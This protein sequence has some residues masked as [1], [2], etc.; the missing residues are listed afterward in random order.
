[1]QKKSGPAGARSVL[2]GVGNW[3]FQA[4]TFKQTKY[5]NK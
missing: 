5:E 3:A 1:M 2:G 4:A